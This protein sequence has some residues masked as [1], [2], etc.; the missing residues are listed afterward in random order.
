MTYII[1]FNCQ[2]LSNH[3]ST[4]ELE[5]YAFLICKVLALILQQDLLAQDHPVQN[6]TYKQ[7]TA[8]SMHVLVHELQYR[9]PQC[10]ES[11]QR[12]QW[13]EMLQEYL[14]NINYVTMY[15]NLDRL[16]SNRCG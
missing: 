8:V 4:A 6:V 9:Q 14:S 12:Q 16:C 1:I 10:R 7:I 11:W 5:L 2:K 13:T 3:Y 15:K